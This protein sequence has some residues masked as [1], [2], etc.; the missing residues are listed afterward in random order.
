MI[1]SVLYFLIEAR[2]NFREFARGNYESPLGAR[3][4]MQQKK[5]TLNCPV[6]P[7][8]LEV[9]GACSIVWLWFENL[10][11]FSFE[12]RSGS[13]R[14]LSRIL[15]PMESQLVIQLCKQL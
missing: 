11:L 1:E 5:V 6:S 13:F 15:K 2:K 7:E 9:L 3:S 14:I 4:Y 12:H 8:Q 10:V